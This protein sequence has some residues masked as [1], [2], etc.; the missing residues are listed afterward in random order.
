MFAGIVGC[1]PGGVRAGRR[2]VVGVEGEERLILFTSD[3]IT[4]TADKGHTSLLELCQTV[5]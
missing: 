3:S 2:M 1:G 4:A 5:L